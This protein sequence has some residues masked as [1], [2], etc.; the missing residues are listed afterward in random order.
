MNGYENFDNIIRKNAE[1]NSYFFKRFDKIENVYADSPFRQ[2]FLAK[3]G[4]G[5][6]IK[7]PMEAKPKWNLNE[8]SKIGPINAHSLKDSSLRKTY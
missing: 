5:N 1:T 4:S 2:N 7:R 8:I 3:I 6:D